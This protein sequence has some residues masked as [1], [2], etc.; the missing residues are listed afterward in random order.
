K[1]DYACSRERSDFALLQDCELL[2]APAHDLPP[3]ELEERLAW[4]QA[5]FAGRLWLA[6]ELLLDGG[7]D[8]WL[9]QLQE[10]SESTGVP[11]VAAGDVHMHAR[12]RKPLQDVVTA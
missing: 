11:L 1:G 3:A 12:S 8:L 10:A 9:Q 6:A 4:A 7:D 5:L 2:L